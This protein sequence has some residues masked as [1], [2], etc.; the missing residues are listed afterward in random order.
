MC[1]SWRRLGKLGGAPQHDEIEHM[2]VILRCEPK[3]GEGE[4]RRMMA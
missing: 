2:I 1:A 3:L 4:P